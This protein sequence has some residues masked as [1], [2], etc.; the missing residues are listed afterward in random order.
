[1]S[2]TWGF[3]GSGCLLRNGG[4]CGTQRR[5]SKAEEKRVVRGDQNLFIKADASQGRPSARA[6]ICKWHSLLWRCAGCKKQIYRC[7]L[8]E[9]LAK[10]VDQLCAL[11][12]AYPDS[13]REVAT[14]VGCLIW[15]RGRGAGLCDVVMLSSGVRFSPKCQYFVRCC[16]AEVAA[17]VVAFRLPELP[18]VVSLAQGAN[19]I[20]PS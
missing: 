2:W 12:S 7:A 4:L 16:L 17:E 1:M 18:C 3:R 14:S 15:W 5:L 11:F 13:C 8:E 6:D 9:N 20:N 19:R 10:R